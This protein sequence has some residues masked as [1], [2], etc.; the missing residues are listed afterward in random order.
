[1]NQPPPI[2]FVA[3]VTIE[4]TTS[5]HVGACR[6]ADVAD[7]AVVTDANGLPAIPG[8]S[9]AGVLRDAFAMPHGSND[10]RAKRVFGY[11]DSRKPGEDYPKGEG[12]HLSVS[13]GCIHDQ[14]NLPVEGLITCDD[15]LEDEVLASAFAPTVRDHVRINHQGVADAE[16]HGKFDE[17]AVCPGHRFTF[18]LVLV[19]DDADRDHWLALLRLLQFGG[20]RFGGKT[21][22]GFGAFKVERL[23][24]KEFKLNTA[25]GRKAWLA[26]PV[27]LRQEKPALPVFKDEASNTGATMGDLTVRLALAPRGYWMFG[28]GADEET[29]AD[30][31]PVRESRVVWKTENGASKGSVESDCFLIPGASIKGAIAHRVAFH[32]NVLKENF[33]KELVEDGKSL[34]SVCGQHSEAVK[35]LFGTAIDTKDGKQTGQAG[36]ILIDDV[37]IPPG[38][39]GTPERIEQQFI[40]HVGIDRF[41][42]GA[43][44]G[45]LFNERPVWK[46]EAIEIAITVR[47]AAEVHEPKIRTALLL[48]LQD[49]AGGRLQLGAGSGRGLGWFEVA[50]GESALRTVSEWAGEKP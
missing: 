30:M 37:L 8:S 35:Q 32:Y 50:D 31:A 42:G 16:E 7:A 2:R 38:K 13:W 47:N 4:F 36:R 15:I 40:N 26:Y 33:A 14:A 34:E 29:D 49:L 1:M 12:S 24:A 23:L 11:Q 10:A 41:T 39:V 5:F 28:G 44:E 3:L 45:V 46:G 17:L 25:E 6:G 22:R 21:R 18:E 9:I 27:E 20:L 48:T 43:M 19:G